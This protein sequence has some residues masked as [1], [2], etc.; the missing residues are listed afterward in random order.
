ANAFAHESG[1]HQ[2]GMLANR[3][4]YEIMTPESVGLNKSDLV[5]GKHSGR[6]AFVAKL[7]ELG[8]DL[9]DKTIDET[10]ARFKT[11]ADKKKE[12]YDQ[13]IIA[14]INPSTTRSAQAIEFVDLW[15]ECGNKG[16]KAKL[17]VAIDGEEYSATTSGNGPVDA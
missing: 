8:M 16:Q 15:V 17:T 14:L 10:F 4:T 13:D 2:H 7:K 5:L 11:L 9:P 3:N 6:H 12:S 1:I